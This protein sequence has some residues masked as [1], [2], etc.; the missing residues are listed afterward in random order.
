[1]EMTRPNLSAVEA[2]R[3][4]SLPGEVG[5]PLYAKAVLSLLPEAPTDELLGTAL[6]SARS[7]LGNAEP[8]GNQ[9]Y[10]NLLQRAARVGLTVPAPPRSAQD[11]AAW[12][13][14]VLTSGRQSAAAAEPPIRAALAAGEAAGD[15]LLAAG[16][17][18]YLGPLLQAAPEHPGLR[19]RAEESAQLLS[20]AA[21]RLILA[22]RDPALPGAVRDPGD[23]L[24]A[25][26]K[27]IPELPAATSGQ[28]GPD[29]HDLFLQ[30]ER[31]LGELTAAFAYPAE[32]P[33]L[34][35]PTPEEDALHAEILAHPEQDALRRR[36]AELA[37]RR[38]DPRAELIR[39]QFAIR[40]LRHSGAPRAK[41][42]PHEQRAA[43][44][45]KFHPEW[46]EDVLRLGASSV[47]FYRGFI[48]LIDIDTPTFLRHA[49]ALY[50]AAPLQHLQLRN[51]AGHLGELGAAPHLARIRS[52][53]LCENGL[54]D[55]DVAALVGSP[56]L[57]GLRALDLSR[58]RLTD[59]AVAA[60]A[61][62]PNLDALR[63]LN[64][65]YNPCADPVDG[66][67]YSDDVNWVWA[68]REAGK[69][70]EAKYGPKPYLHPTTEQWPGD[71]DLL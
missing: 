62:T 20:E 52:L 11:H 18:S 65:D 1:M 27:R 34:G 31:E 37:A 63:Y 59:A 33:V 51:A 22:L 28:P 48:G 56:H 7:R 30:V 5:L 64:V 70:L 10:N 43:A 38:Q 32:P 53:L 55:A 6:R 46:A 2:F 40:E 42:V 35:P 58:N 61:A 69:A 60:I 47:R 17:A 45:I 19:R 12:A 57:R 16:T 14:A 41:D 9:A 50:R 23:R 21:R 67:Y 8:R 13:A 3:I 66:R 36:Y 71:I 26:L 15:V 49:E 39:C 24:T 54:G 25:L 44:L 4:A 68:P 29:P